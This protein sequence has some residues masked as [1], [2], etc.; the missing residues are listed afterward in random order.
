MAIRKLDYEAFRAGY[1]AGHAAGIRGDAGAFHEREKE[2]R[3]LA[4]SLAEQLE[5]KRK[6]IRVLSE[7]KSA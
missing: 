6:I 7:R 2:W 3:A 5:E 1:Q 4:I